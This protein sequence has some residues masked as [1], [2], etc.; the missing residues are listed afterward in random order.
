M[1][2]WLWLLGSTVVWAACS[3]LLALAAGRV[4]RHFRVED[5]RQEQDRGFA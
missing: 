4:F 3:V 2:W 1:P 5:R